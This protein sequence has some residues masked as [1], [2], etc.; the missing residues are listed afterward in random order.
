MGTWTAICPNQGVYA[1]EGH[2]SKKGEGLVLHLRK[3]VKIKDPRGESCESKGNPH[4][5]TA[6]EKKHPSILRK[7]RRCIKKVELKCCGKHTKDYSKC[8]CNPVAVCRATI[9]CP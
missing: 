4:G 6:C 9:P 5:L 8:E 7:I 3:V 2:Y 1:G